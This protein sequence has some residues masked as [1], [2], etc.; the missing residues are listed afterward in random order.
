MRLFAKNSAVSIAAMGL[1]FSVVST[2]GCSA[3]FG[4]TFRD[5]ADDY[6]QHENAELMTET[7]S[8][9]F[10]DGM[11]LP[12]VEGDV[13]LTEEF[14]VPRPEK[15]AAID[16]EQESA[17]LSDYQGENLNP[18]LEKDGAGTQVLRMDGRFAVAWTSVA[19]AMADASFKLED[20]N[21]SIGTYY[22][23][24][25]SLDQSEDQSLWEWLFGSDEEMIE[26]Q[27]LL[28][29]NRS[30]LGVYLSLQQDAETLADETLTA[31]VL[32]EIKDLLSAE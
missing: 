30:R 19:E 4:D 10:V 14:V 13:S 25:E 28:K 7:D 5:R 22:L 29:M 32:E 31:L 9:V 24:I 26:Q 23:A 3:I 18:R 12:E 17:S 11:P 1:I 2:T 15:L 21:R 20:M 8:L 27:Y 16:E 6:L